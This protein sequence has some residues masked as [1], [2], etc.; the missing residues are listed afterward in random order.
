MPPPFVPLRW[1]RVPEAQQFEALRRF[2]ETMR[3]RRTVREFSPE[4]V[5]VELIEQ[6]IA[7]AGM[8]PSGANQQPWRFVIVSDPAIKKEIRIAAEA[9]EKENYEHR[10]PREWLE[11]LGPFGTDWHKEFLEIA[12]YLIVVFRLDYGIEEDERK[13][14]H[15]YVSESV[16]IAAGF[17][18]AALHVAGL[19][20]LTHTP[21]PMGFLGR[22]CRR[23][24]NE[25]P[26][27]L[28]P[29]GYPADSAMVPD[30]SKK[31]QAEITVRL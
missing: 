28:V 18:L 19:A 25:R 1:E 8:A 26:F 14:K 21:N 12:P 24:A 17:L 15:Y 20:T 5:P 7:I 11:A 2:Q 13:V 10:F 31:S 23:P 27:L 6:A 9:E 22:I 4:P 16:G 30:I 29:V 3:R